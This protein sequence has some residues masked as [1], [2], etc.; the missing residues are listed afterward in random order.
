MPGDGERHRRSRSD[1]GM[2][3]HRA[4]MQADIAADQRQP[5]A[6]DRR[7][8]AFI[9]AVKRTEYPL[10]LFR[11]NADTAVGH[12][13]SNPLAASFGEHHHPA[14][15]RREVDAV[16][17]QVMKA[18]AQPSRSEEH[19]SELQSLMRISYAVFCLKKKKT[20]II[21][22]LHNHNQE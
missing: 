21:Q 10:L 20:K 9:L 22:Q 12:G 11:R 16:R 17:Q 2:K 3:L 15:R 7:A 6:A 14:A 8:D 13:D 5:K 18:G 4:A 1:F 19:T